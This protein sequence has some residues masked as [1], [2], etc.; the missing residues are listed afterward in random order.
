[1][2]TTSVDENVY[3][4]NGSLSGDTITTTGSQVVVKVNTSDRNPRVE[5]D[6]VNDPIGPDPVVI[7]SPGSGGSDVP[8]RKIKDLL[9]L[10]ETISV[11]GFLSE[12]DSTSA[13]SKRNDLNTLIKFG[14]VITVVWGKDADSEQQSHTGTIIKSKVTEGSGR[15]QQRTSIPDGPDRHFM[16]FVQILVG[17]DR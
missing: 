8:T 17:E 1:M 9:R 6:Y 2:A 15:V 13:L 3:L 5:Y 4:T 10:R 12:E 16:V 11:T 14:K 7:D